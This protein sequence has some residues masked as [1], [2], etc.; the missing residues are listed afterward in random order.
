M[1]ALFSSGRHA[2]QEN[3]THQ[4]VSESGWCFALNIPCQR[5]I[6]HR[7]KI[8]VCLG[9]SPKNGPLFILNGWF[10]LN[11][12]PNLW[13]LGSWLD[14]GEPNRARP[15]IQLKVPR[16]CVVLFDDPFQIGFGGVLANGTPQ[17]RLGERPKLKEP[18]YRKQPKERHAGI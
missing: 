2:H 3:T 11:N 5:I 7:C 15:G 9:I 6:F 1:G 4:N 16:P 14:H 17:V 8:Q 13:F 10:L 12:N 18:S